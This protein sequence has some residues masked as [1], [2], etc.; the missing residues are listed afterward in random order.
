MQYRFFKGIKISEV[1][2][3][4]WQFGNADWGQIKGSEAL[5]ILQAFLDAG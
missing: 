1:G 3:G 2:L 4:T 5:A